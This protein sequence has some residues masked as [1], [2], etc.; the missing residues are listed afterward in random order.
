MSEHIAVAHPV[1]GNQPIMIK[2]HQ[3]PIMIQGHQQPTMI[4]GHQQPMMIQGHPQQPIMI[5]VIKPRTVVVQEKYCGG[6]SW[7]SC[8]LLTLFVPPLCI[9]V[10]LCPCDTKDVIVSVPH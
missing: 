10:P 8:I 5:K 7:C 6:V 1:P 9:F 4:Q 3:Q 2:G